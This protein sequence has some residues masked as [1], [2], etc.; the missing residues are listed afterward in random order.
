MEVLDSLVRQVSESAESLLHAFSI[1]TLHS[2][3]SV[4]ATLLFTLCPLPITHM[5][6]LQKNMQ[7]RLGL[8]WGMPFQTKTSENVFVTRVQDLFICIA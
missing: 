4:A 7:Q 5:K 6:H 2:P 1:G 8:R 3:Q